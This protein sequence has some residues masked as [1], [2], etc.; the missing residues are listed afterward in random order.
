VGFDGAVTSFTEVI[1]S[2]SCTWRDLAIAAPGVPAGRRRQLV[3]SADWTKRWTATC[4][5]AGGEVVAPVRNLASMPSAGREPVRRFSWHRAQRHRPGLTYMVS[6]NRQHGCESLAEARLL[7]MLDFAGAVTEVLPQPMQLRFLAVDG[8]REHT[9][10]FFVESRSQQWLID[11]RP[12]GRIGEQDEVAFAASAEVATLLDW[13]YTV[14]TG[15]KPHSLTTVDTLSSQRRPLTYR[16]GMVD[17]LSAAVA[18]GSRTFGELAAGTIAP[19]VARAY[20]LHLLWHRRE[21]TS[22]M[23]WAM[24]TRGDYRAAPVLRAKPGL[25]SHLRDLHRTLDSA[26]DFTF[27]EDHQV[28]TR[29]GR[30]LRT[31]LAALVSYRNELEAAIDVGHGDVVACKR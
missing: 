29:S 1:W 23:L 15:W 14:I 11:V 31:L 12:A 17:A 6:T 20:L 2:H 13:G 25:L 8:P 4:R 30:Q 22:L 26:V 21:A 9:P 16:L 3:L 5:Y 10:D 7:L 27:G 18:G 28:N 24:I 19:A